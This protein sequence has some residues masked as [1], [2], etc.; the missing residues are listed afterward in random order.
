MSKICPQL[1]QNLETIKTLKSE[2]DL[3]LPKL[4]ELFKIFKNNIDSQ[5]RKNN[6]T[7]RKEIINKIKS[8]KT[9]LNLNINKIEENFK[10]VN[11]FGLQRWFKNN[12]LEKHLDGGSLEKLMQSQ[13][14]YYQKMYGADFKIDYSKIKIERD[15]LPNIKKALEAGCANYPQLIATPE[16]LTNEEKEMTEAEFNYTRGIKM[17]EKEGLKIWDKEGNNRWT[18]LSIMECL[19]GYIPVKVSDFNTKDLEADWIKEIQRVIALKKSAPKVKEG[20]IELSF[21]DNRQDIPQKQKIIN[22]KG[23][24]VENKYS[25]IEM[26]KSEVEVVSPNKWL[27]QAFQN[28]LKDKIYL[29]LNTW[30]WMMAVLDH[31]GKKTDPPV[32]AA[33]AFSDSSGVNLDSYHASYDFGDY[34]WRAVF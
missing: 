22:T 8:L 9:E 21:I 31:K 2:L 23:E 25:F 29:S 14:K 16:K 3:E 32:S 28:Y 1:K 34:R 6:K 15:R 18:N 7:E 27:T 19:K 24:L 4:Q 10:F 30:D 13:E 33:I 12:N 5:R 17:L 11:F 26:V 20:Q